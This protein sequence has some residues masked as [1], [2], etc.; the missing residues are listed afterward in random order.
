MALVSSADNHCK[1]F[2]KPRSGPTNL[3]PN[4]LTLMIFLKEFFEKVDFKISR[5]QKSMQNYP[6]GKEL[7]VF[8][9]P[10]KIHILCML[11]NFSCLCCFSKLTFSK[12]QERYHSVKQLGLVPNRVQTVCKGYQ[13]LTKVV[14]KMI[15]IFPDNIVWQYLQR[16]WKEVFIE[17]KVN[18]HFTIFARHLKCIKLSILTI[19]SIIT[20]FDAF[21]ISCI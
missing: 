6:V 3:D 1:Q 21:E 11:G 15:F 2:Y 4:C 18:S 8:Y 14:A 20:P 9:F 13:Q 5:R 12:N 7:N 19:Y 16:A 17:V 10:G